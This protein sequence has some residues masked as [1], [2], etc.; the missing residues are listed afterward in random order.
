MTEGWYSDEHLILFDG[1]EVTSASER[2]AISQFLPGNRV[3]GLRG[4]DYFILQ[5][6][7]GRTYSVASVPIVAAHLL[8]YTLPPAGSTLTPDDRFAG[9]IKWYVTPTVFGGDPKLGKNVIWV[10]HEQ[11]AQLVRWWNGLC[12][13]LTNV[14]AGTIGSVKADRS[15]RQFLLHHPA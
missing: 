1:A 4:W 10:S 14:P 3:I 5:D 6:S 11:H 8:P 2:Y 13:S 7:V 12:R 9:R 15:D